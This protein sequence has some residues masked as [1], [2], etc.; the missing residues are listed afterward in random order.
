MTTEMSTLVQPARALLAMTAFLALSSCIKG[1]STGDDA[2]TSSGGRGGAGGATG[3]Q[4]GPDPVSGVT[5]CVGTTECPN[6]NVD[7][8]TFPG[9]GYKTTTPSFDLECV[10][11]G[12]TLCPIGVAATCADI[13]PLFAKRT[14]R[15][16]CNQIGSG[17]C[18][19]VGTTPPGT[20]GSRS[21]TCDPTCSAE[22][23]GSPTCLQACGC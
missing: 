7:P 10:C 11:D 9:C 13:A 6:A 22:C 4:C 2:G 5:L 15:D 19:E 20:G 16:V 14:V 8:D 12:N 17:S 18:I 1:K 23:A 3:V 21:S